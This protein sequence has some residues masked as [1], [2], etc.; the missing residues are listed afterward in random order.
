LPVSI[1]PYDLPDA[2]LF[3]GA[4]DAYSIWQPQKNYIVLGLSNTPER[5]L[6]TENIIRAGI[7]VTKR[8]SGG[9]A[10]ML[11]P[12]TVVFAISRTFP[13]PVSSRDYF[14]I[15]NELIVDYLRTKGVNN[16]GFKGI[17]DITIGN[18]KIL[19]SSIRSR[20]TRM[21]Y[22]AVLNVSEDPDLFEKYLRHPV[23]E[24][25]YRAQ[26]SHKEFVTS[27]KTEGFNITIDELISDISQA[28]H[29]YLFRP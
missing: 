11:T 12:R 17:S 10:M 14:R 27:L 8:P 4:E 24:P 6:F 21:T 19:G 13:V 18:N 29:H 9:E 15:I 22:H 23:K 1:L 25:D 7:P 26:R 20:R 28:F 16:L 3:E 2:F 5:S